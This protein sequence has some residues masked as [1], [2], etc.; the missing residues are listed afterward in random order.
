MAG[1]E[2]GV[3]VVPRVDP[4]RHRR[5]HLLG[6][7]GA[8]MGAFAGLLRAA[9]FQVTGSDQNAYPPMSEWLRAW[10]IPVLTPY[11]PENL[12]RA[13]P[14]LVVVGNVIR[15]QNPEATAARERAL[16]QTS[17]PAALG[18]LF[19]EGRHPVVVAGTHGKTTTS[20][21]LAH[22][23]V[24]AGRDPSYLVGGLPRG[25]ASFRLGQ[26][27]HV[28]VEG[29][30]YDTA[31]FDKSPKFLHYR[32]RTAI[33]T[34]VELDHVDIYRDLAHY[35]TA[36]ERFVALLPPGGFLAVCAAY[37]DACR[38]AR[39]SRARVV[40]Y[41]V[42]APGAEYTAGGLEL[43]P[44]GASFEVW[45]E[46]CLL[47][48]VRLPL[49]G[50]HNVANALGVVAA[51]RSLGLDLEEI[52]AGL[53]SFPGVHRRQEVRGEVKGVAVV[54]DFAHHPTAVRETLAAVAAAYPGRRLWA[55]F[56]PRSNTSRRRLHQ[57]EYV[58]ALAGARCVRLRVPEPHDQVPP[59]E[60]LDVGRLVADL[61]A[62]GVDAAAA[63]GVG[64]LVA[65]VA[66]E[67]RPGDVVVVMSNG[68]FGGFADRLLAA[69]A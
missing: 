50:R 68:P 8:G 2:A 19:L 63:A 51:A 13:C 24:S 42:E 57:A 11:R 26:G 17:F 59:E 43:G 3:R 25:G 67:V 30:E 21:L 18:D 39:Q 36:F 49:G 1:P 32:P 65:E 45:E 14:D 35:Q 60:T 46:G 54:D 41:G 62:R 5:L 34:S 66:A 61:R 22:V 29:D 28:V 44:G 4:G 38:I 55:V 15:R 10:G 69:L 47:G 6:I 31:Y 58:D 53:A 23:L 7:A 64:D 20:A 27:P 37:P 56:E 40:R 52:R 9:G 12:D 33:L 16:P 48:E